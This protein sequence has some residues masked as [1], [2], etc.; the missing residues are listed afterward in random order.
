M[1]ACH[2]P[3]TITAAAPDTR[4]FGAECQHGHRMA[5]IIS[6]SKYRKQREL[7]VRRS[8]AAESRLRFGR[9]ASERNR[10]RLEYLKAEADL[11]ARRVERDG[12][13]SAS[14]RASE[15]PEKD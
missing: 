8:Q 9:T 6:F 7:A 11:D 1:R 5:E 3:P 10:F 13:G 12:T 14:S 15:P 2:H 4:W